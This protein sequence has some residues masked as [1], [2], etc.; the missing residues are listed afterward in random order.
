MTP[1]NMAQVRNLYSDSGLVIPPGSP[2]TT[3][4][5][6][7]RAFIIDS[8]VPSSDFVPLTYL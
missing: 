4:T 3:A 6:L 7:L 8:T 1:G 5:G 2:V